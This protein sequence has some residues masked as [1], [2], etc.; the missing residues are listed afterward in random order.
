[1]LGD[2]FLHRKARRAQMHSRS[3][4]ETVEDLARRPVSP[5]TGAGTSAVSYWVAGR[6]CSGGVAS[7]VGGL[8]VAT[9]AEGEGRQSSGG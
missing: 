1:M 5:G 8:G 4:S 6:D 7:Q 2:R 9:L 3:P